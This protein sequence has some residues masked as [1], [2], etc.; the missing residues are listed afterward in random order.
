MLPEMRIIEQEILPKLRERA[1]VQRAKAARQLAQWRGEK[2]VCSLLLSLREEDI[3]ELRYLP[4]YDLEEI[5]GDIEKMFVSQLRGAL[6]TAF[7]DGEAVPS[8][9][10]NV[11][12]GCINT[13]L[14]GLRQTY[15]P[16]KMPWLLQHLTA[17]EMASLTAADITDSEEF[18]RGLEEMR[19]MKTMLEGTGVEVY[20]MDLQG[21]IDMAHLWLGNEFFYLLY[22]DPE[23]VHHVLGLAVECLDYAWHKNMEIIQPTD[24]LCHYN[25]F[26]LP[27]GHPVK[28]S[29]DTSTLL[30]KAHIEEYMIPYTAE[31]FRR[32]G[33]GYI[34]YCGN[35]QHL[36]PV[37]EAFPGSFGLNFGNPERHDFGEVLPALWKNGKFY[38]G[39]ALP[40]TPEEQ[41][42]AAACP[43]GTF[44]LFAVMSCAKADQPRVLEKFRALTEKYRQ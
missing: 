15:F 23:L 18:T 10:A 37:T 22:D 29:E 41:V 44:N 20:P 16:D 19:F 9:R 1:D 3:P 39:A 6:T 34:H 27:I 17:E 2:G 42:R 13:L 40:C 25:S 38:L 30:S 8:V 43:D 31:V 32:L 24:H 11:G 36:L 35:N 4:N 5:H 26:V 28:L 7:A 12:C 33:G 14:G 21:P